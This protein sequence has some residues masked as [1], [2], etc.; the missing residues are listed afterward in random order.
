MNIDLNSFKR[1]ISTMIFASIVVQT[2][3][4]MEFLVLDLTATIVAVTESYT[5]QSVGILIKEE[6]CFQRMIKN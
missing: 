4:L 3:A 5:H 1:V 6:T 2:M